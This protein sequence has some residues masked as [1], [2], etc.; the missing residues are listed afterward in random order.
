MT[1]SMGIKWHARLFDTL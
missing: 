1:T